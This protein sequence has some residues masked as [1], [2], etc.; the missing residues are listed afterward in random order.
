L[1]VLADVA[2]EGL[3]QLLDLLEDLLGAPALVRRQRHARV[4]EALQQVLLELRLVRV[5]G[6]RGGHAREELLVLE[7]I[8][9]EGRELLQ[10]RLRG[11]AH[12]LVGRDVAQEVDRVQH[13]LDLDREA[14]PFVEDRAGALLRLHLLHGGLH[15]GEALV[16]RAR[17]RG[18]VEERHEGARGG[19]GVGRGQRGGRR[20]DGNEVTHGS[21]SVDG[22]VGCGA[23]S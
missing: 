21:C 6:L 5:H 8:R 22:Q 19:G 14:V 11:V 10:A 9:L 16:A 1:K 17:D 7:E 20:D 3:A 18:R 15:A 12:R 23:S 13:V 4:L 2:V